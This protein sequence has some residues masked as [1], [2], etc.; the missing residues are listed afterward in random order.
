MDSRLSNDD[1]GVRDN[2]SIYINYI[3][4]FKVFKVRREQMV[5]VWISSEGLNRYRDGEVTEGWSKEIS[6]R[7]FIIQ[8][9]IPVEEIIAES[10][11]LDDVKFRFRKNYNW[12][13]YS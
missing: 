6:K 8:M 7:G 10:E 5:T 9:S 2:G 1:C 13:D 3:W 12:N 11:W 4:N